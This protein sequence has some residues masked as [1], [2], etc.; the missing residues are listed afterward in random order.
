[1]F[2]DPE[3]TRD[4]SDL[5]YSRQP[6][7]ISQTAAWRSIQVAHYLHPPWETPQYF[8][9][10]HLIQVHL[11]KPV[12]MLLN[13]SGNC[14]D[15][16]LTAGDISIYTAGSL[17]QSRWDQVAEFINLYI[18]PD[19]FQRLSAASLSPDQ[20]RLLQK[21][22]VRDPLIQQIGQVLKTELE[23]NGLMN[24]FYAESLAT[25]LVAHLL[26]R[27]MLLPPTLRQHG[28][29]LPEYC[30]QQ[31]MDHVHAHLAED[32]SLDELAAIAQISPYYFAR[33]FKQSIGVSPHQYVIQRRIER[34]K[35]LLQDDQIAI[36][37]VALQCGFPSHSHF[38]K[39]FQHQTG[40]TPKRYR[41]DHKALGDGVLSRRLP[42]SEFDH[43]ISF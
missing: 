4:I 43:R 8:A 14:H 33:L 15:L 27:Y 25:A 5:V 41:H 9:L 18:H 35:Q 23:T 10:A 11:G 16:Q 22:Q 40:M 6:L 42:E 34:A 31:V 1:M 3:K 26:R 37:D 20:A 39:L 28:D 38:T 13:L 29:G 21:P 12:N 7:L 17:I 30:L 32:L 2:V 24:R 36:A 19:F